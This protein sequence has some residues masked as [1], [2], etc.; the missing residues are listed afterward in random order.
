M[1]DLFGL[2]VSNAFTVEELF[3]LAAEKDGGVVVT[4]INPHSYY[5][6]LKDPSYKSLLSEFDI[7]FP[8]GVG[9]VQLAQL[10]GM[11]KV[12]RKSFDNS[13]IAP[14]VFEYCSKN[15][16][17][18]GVV[19]GQEGVPEKF[20][21]AVVNEYPSLKVKAISHGFAAIDVIKSSVKAANVDC[22]IIGMGIPYQE[23]VALAIR[24]KG[25]SVFTCGGFLDQRIESLEYYPQL[26]DD[27][28][29]R[30]LYRLYKEP[31]RLW[32]RY[33]VEYR[34]FLLLYVKAWFSKGIGK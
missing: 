3:S 27:L 13:S 18:L 34:T 19:G 28:N 21:N 30:F 9:V 15:G 23:K 33:L 26:V 8:D 11:T 5:M 31:R 14:E 20:V 16:L 25:L 10:V 4:F 24:T 7:V 1:N 2:P 29:V 12:R 17:S 6:C 32:R 22:V